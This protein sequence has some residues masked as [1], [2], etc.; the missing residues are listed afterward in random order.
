MDNND[1]TPAQLYGRSKNSSPKAS[2]VFLMGER[3][4]GREPASEFPSFNIS[5][6]RKTSSLSP[7]WP[8]SFA[9]LFF[10]PPLVS[11]MRRGRSERRVTLRRR[12]KQRKPFLLFTP[13]VFF[14]GFVV[15]RLHFILFFWDGKNDNND[16]EASDEILCSTNIPILKQGGISRRGETP[17]CELVALGSDNISIEDAVA[18]LKS[19][20]WQDLG[21]FQ[22]GNDQR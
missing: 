15:V 10:F 4:S 8:Y 13:A 2:G 9:F 12:E 19:L 14:V 11:E 1:I 20:V 18:A 6:L 7:T 16:H 22:W 5:P 21:Y 3:Q 17:S